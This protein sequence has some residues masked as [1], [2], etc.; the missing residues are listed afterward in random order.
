[1]GVHGPSPTEAAIR[2]EGSPSGG[3]GGGGGGGGLIAGT[4][5]QYERPAVTYE[6]PR[7]QLRVACR[8]RRGPPLACLARE[9][10]WLRPRNTGDD[11]SSHA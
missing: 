9:R 7:G 8:L 10:P 2:G 3:G 6:L 11:E 1:M 4:L 5:R